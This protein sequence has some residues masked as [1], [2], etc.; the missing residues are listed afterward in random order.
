MGHV[1]LGEASDCLGR[2][3][4]QRTAAGEYLFTVDASPQGK[5]VV[6]YRSVVTSANAVRLLRKLQ[7]GTWNGRRSRVTAAGIA[8]LTETPT[9]SP[10]WR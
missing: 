3:R 2:M 7:S 8:M 10:R 5:D 9:R 4:L 6:Q 1:L